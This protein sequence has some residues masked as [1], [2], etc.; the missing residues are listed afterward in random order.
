[1]QNRLK[2]AL[3]QPDTRWADPPANRE[4]LARL[5]E[6][7]PGCDLYVLPETCTTG[8]LGNHERLSELVDDDDIGWFRDQAGQRAAAIAGSVVAGQGDRIFN[9]F[10]LARPDGNTTT[11]DKRHLFGF[12]GEGEYYTAGDAR[13]RTELAGWKVDLQICY[14]LRFPVWC[15]NDADFDLQLFV[16]NWPSPRVNAWSTLLRARAIENQAY[17]IG[18]NRVGRDGKDVD[19][20]GRS[21]AWDMLGETLFEADDRERVDVVTLD[22]SKLGEVREKFR[23]LA[24]RDAFELK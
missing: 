2:C 21:G 6:Q 19:Y 1:M 8:F 17:V 22:A 20:P 11:Y 9:R 24:D 3:I 16:A 4:N 18:V 14:D 10:V 12:G 13:V 15:R 7:A 23:F 5:M